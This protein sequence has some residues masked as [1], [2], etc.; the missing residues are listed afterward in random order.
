MQNQQQ[1]QQQQFSSQ[2]SLSQAKTP[3]MPGRAS[4]I[5]GRS[6]ASRASSIGGS[7]SL[8]PSIANYKDGKAINSSEI[9]NDVIRVSKSLSKHIRNFKFTLH[10]ILLF[11]ILQDLDYKQPISAK[12]LALPSTSVFYSVFEVF[13]RFI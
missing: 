11:K 4:S 7:T 12:I 1:Q 6:F 8:R 10:L 3:V 2:Y 13:W 9:V 5:D